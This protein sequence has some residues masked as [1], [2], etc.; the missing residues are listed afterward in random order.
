[1]RAHEE[2]RDARTYLALYLAKIGDKKS[3]LAEIGRI[4]KAAQT[5]AEVLFRLA[6]VHELCGERDHALSALAGSLKAGYGV[7][8]IKN[9]PELIALRADPRYQSI[10][11]SGSQK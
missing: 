4:D 8:E 7:G 3:A 5:D 2:D 6:V 1:M 11:G 9:E 10:L